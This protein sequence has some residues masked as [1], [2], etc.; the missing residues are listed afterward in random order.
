MRLQRCSSFQY[1]G[2]L[3]VGEPMSC[4]LAADTRGTTP[5]AYWRMS[6]SISGRISGTPNR[7]GDTSASSL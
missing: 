2:K 1:P 5:P 6:S 3:H 4:A 7:Y